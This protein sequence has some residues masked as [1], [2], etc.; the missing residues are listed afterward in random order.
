MTFGPM[1][2]FS[3]P[4]N[5]GSLL[6]PGFHTWSVLAPNRDLTT[7]PLWHYIIHM[8]NNYQ[9][10]GPVPAPITEPIWIIFISYGRY[11]IS[12]LPPPS[13]LE[14]IE[15][16]LLHCTSSYGKTFQIVPCPNH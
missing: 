6:E 15:K 14:R 12:R 5:G 4:V 3:I 10:R 1:T 13:I 16:I 11:V 2:P 8:L 7:K 9:I